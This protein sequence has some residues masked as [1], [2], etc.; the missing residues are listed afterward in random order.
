MA[1]KN[2]KIQKMEDDTNKAIKEA[3]K[4]HKGKNQLDRDVVLATAHQ[5]IANIRSAYDD[6]TTL[7]EAVDHTEASL[8]AIVDEIEKAS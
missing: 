2:P 1:H 3:G 8:D 7:K 6:P 4:H 5:I